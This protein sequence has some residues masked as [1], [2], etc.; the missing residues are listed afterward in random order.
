VTGMSPIL[1]EPRVSRP[2]STIV[3][4][5]IGPLGCAFGDE[6]GSA[7]RARAMSDEIRRPV[8]QLANT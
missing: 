5:A 1:T 8:H 6:I 7:S 4:S 2:R 3:G